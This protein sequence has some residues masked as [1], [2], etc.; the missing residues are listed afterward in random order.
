MSRI[1]YNPSIINYYISII[2]CGSNT[3]VSIKYPNFENLSNI[4]YSLS[5]VNRSAPILDG[6]QKNDL[7]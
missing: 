3:S 4:N 1:I 6:S 7:F 2:Y 5:P